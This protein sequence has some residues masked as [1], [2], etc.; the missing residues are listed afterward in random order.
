MSV[1]YIIIWL[2][3]PPMLW[4]KVSL[5]LVLLACAAFVLTRPRPTV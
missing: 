3:G 5:G 2:A 4:L 1:S